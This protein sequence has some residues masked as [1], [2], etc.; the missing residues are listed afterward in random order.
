MSFPLTLKRTTRLARGVTD[1]ERRAKSWFSKQWTAFSIYTGQD[2][3]HEQAN[4]DEYNQN[5]SRVSR[6]LMGYILTSPV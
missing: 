1:V 3:G 6:K 4:N 5:N 2:H